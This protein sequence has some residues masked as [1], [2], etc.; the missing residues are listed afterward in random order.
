MF[1]FSALNDQ[2]YDEAATLITYC[3]IFPHI[4]KDFVTRIDTKEMMKSSNLPV[5]TDVTVQPGIS[6]SVAAITFKGATES[7]GKGK[8]SGNTNPAYDGSTLLPG[9]ES[10][11]KQKES[12]KNSGGAI[13]AATIGG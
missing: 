11:K 7:V 10:L 6:L 8:G 3:K 12:I 2:A 13:T 5:S 1:V 9:D 4:V